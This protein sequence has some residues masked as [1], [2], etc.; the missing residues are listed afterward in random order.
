MRSR[1]LLVLAI[2]AALAGLTGCS[3]YT[4]P[5]RGADL[6]PDSLQRMRAQQADVSIEKLLA[7]KPLA[8]FPTAIAVVRTQAP[9]YRSYTVHSS[10]GDGAYSVVT[11]RD[12]EKD[13][14]FTRLTKLPMVRGIAPMN[15]LMLPTT[16]NTDQPL[17]QAAARLGADMLLIYTIDTTFRTEDEAKPLTVV[18]LGLSP[19][20]VVFVN[21][22]ASALL[23]DTRNGYIYGTAEASESEK[24]LTNAW[25]N[26]EAADQSRRR[27]ETAAFEKLVGEIEKTWT[28]VVA[29]YAK[30]ATASA[31]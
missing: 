15:R 12:V 6:T 3:S 13:E 26:D 10:Y 30:P 24:Q 7:L 14:Q 27:A 5:G 25:Q 4:A 2:S 28:G 8:Q 19:N 9:Q 11:Q 23:L 20:R 18:T 1:S 21:T 22:T 16:L 29:N 31:K 17:R